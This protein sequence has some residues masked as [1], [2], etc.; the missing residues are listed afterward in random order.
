MPARKSADLPYLDP[1]LLAEAPHAP[2]PAAPRPMLPTLV[3]A[4][5]DHSGWIFEPKF[6]GLRL[7]GRFD[8]NHVTLLSRNDQPQD[9]QFPDI[10]TALRKALAQPAVVDGEVVCLDDNGHTSFRRLQ[11]RFHLMNP[12][13]ILR[14]AQQFP[15]YLF[16][17]DL[18]YWNGCDLR[19]L[20]LKERKKI[21]RKVVRW[22]ARIRQ[23][24]SRPGKGTRKR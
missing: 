24:K 23:T 10:S 15:A 18:L 1:A 16:L 12:S 7:L 14:R 20:P 21:L 19:E 6:D 3:A 5:F 4:P 13:E 8:G 9:L 22:S 11:Q 2:L 17:F